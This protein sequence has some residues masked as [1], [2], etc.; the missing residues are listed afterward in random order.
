MK[1]ASRFMIMALSVLSM[2]AFVSCSDDDDKEERP[3]QNQISV[4][5]KNPSNDWRKALKFYA[6]NSLKELDAPYTVVTA[7]SGE[8]QGEDIQKMVKNQA[9]VLIIVPEDG[10]SAEDVNAA[11]KHRI[12]VILGETEIEGV[13]GYT[14]AVLF[15]NQLVGE[16]AAKFMAEQEVKNILAFE[17]EQDPAT[18]DLRIDSFKE[19]MEELDA[20]ATVTSV[21]VEEYT[22]KA[23]KEAI[24]A[25]LE[26][27]E[28]FEYD[29]IYAQD[30]E[31]ALGILEALEAAEITSVKVIVGCGGSQDYFK[32]IESNEDIIL[33]TTLYSPKELMEKCIEIATELLKEND[34]EEKKITLPATIVDSEN[35]EEYIDSSS[36]Y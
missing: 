33:A 28:D 32:A 35:V 19:N 18:S 9:S 29:A 25:L 20:E 30:D 14:A 27:N 22:R 15:D 16:E 2:G 17:V 5:L 21:E 10:L 11:I 1:F 3:D 34:P 7:E 8:K 6:E 4:S 12:P 23:G 26:E 13:T 31:I 36:P 24:E